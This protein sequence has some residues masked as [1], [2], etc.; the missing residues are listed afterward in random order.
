[1]ARTAG[2][3]LIC[4]AVILPAPV[5]AGEPAA[6]LSQREAD[7]WL[8]WVIPLPKQ[9]SIPARRLV[10][11][12]AVKV[13]LHDGAGDVEQFAAREL[14]AL[15]QPK[16]AA[17]SQAAD[18][19]F[20]L[21]LGVCD[22]EGRLGDQT[23]PGAAE[24]AKLPNGEQCYRI[25]PLGEDRIALVGLDPRGVSYAARTFGQLLEPKIAGGKVELPLARITDWPDLAERGIW[26]RKSPRADGGVPRGLWWG[27][28]GY[29]D[30]TLD[31]FSSLKL[32]HQEIRAH[33]LVEKGEPATATLDAGEVNRCR[34]RA[35][36]MIPIVSH[37]EQLGG[38]GIFAAYPETRGQGKHPD[39]ADVICFSQPETQR[40][41]DEW[42]VSLS[43]TVPCDDVM[44]WLSENAVYCTCDRCKPVEQFQHEMQVVIHAWRE[45]QKVRPSLRLRL[46]LT[47]GSN[48]Q[49][50]AIINSAPRDVGITYYDG[51]RTYTVARRPMIPAAMREAI[52]GRWF[53]CCPTLS[54]TWYAIS[55]FAGAA[56]MKERMGE[57]H[58]VG[59]VNLVGFATPSLRLNEFALSAAAEFAWNSSGRTPREFVLAWATRHRL[60]DAEKVAQWWEQIEEPQRDLYISNLTSEGFWPQVARFIADRRGGQPGTGFL[61]GFAKDGRLEADIAGAAHAATI[62]DS[63]PDKRFLH[64]ARY[65]LAALEMA[66]AS[67]DLTVLLAGQKTLSPSK[68]KEAARLFEQ[69][70]L[71]L[72][73]VAEELVAYSRCVSLYPNQKHETPA[74]H[75]PMGWPKLDAIE[76]GAV[77]TARALGV[78]APFMSYVPQRIASWQTGTFPASGEKVDHRID[79]TGQITRPGV[80]LVSFDY[81]RGLESLQIERVALTACPPGGG[82]QEIA[83]DIHRGRAG[84]TNLQ[85]E[86][87]LRLPQYDPQVRYTLLARVG[88]STSQADAQNRTSQGDIHWRQVKE[89]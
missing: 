70:H 47:Q 6:P 3:I 4:V 42:F 87:A 73:Q 66:R 51:G 26:W 74:D 64:E 53:G 30:G 36:K 15:L 77:E 67:R 5:A 89:D 71:A 50:L 19:D 72:A 65:T 81:T 76:R 68:R 58:E 80:Y 48:P 62:A 52:R 29:D 60:T 10:S 83:V 28:S 43:K 54:G 7:A 33:L 88:I 63:I 84:A 57:L 40:I 85:H 25:A 2:C 21:L 32:N 61:A 59:A 46:L 11:L 24:L 86:Y 69:I 49:N 35:I 45:A 79:I 34:L 14:E 18:A 16:E 55:P 12:E 9:A 56:Y 39:W 37:L 75:F 13:R 23:V 31:W 44:V 27:K 1:M 20:E 22:E 17:D 78:D 82:E 8:R 38:S 41:F